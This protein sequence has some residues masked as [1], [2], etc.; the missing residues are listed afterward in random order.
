MKLLFHSQEVDGSK[1]WICGTLFLPDASESGIIRNESQKGQKC[2]LCYPV[3]I[4]LAKFFISHTH[5]V[6]KNTVVG[7]P[8]MNQCRLGWASRCRK[9]TDRSSD[10]EE[11][12]KTC[13]F[14]HLRCSY[15]LKQL[16]SVLGPFGFWVAIPASDVHGVLLLPLHYS[17]LQ[18]LWWPS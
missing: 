13:P 16:K 7:W 6:V 17:D 9:Q 15:H 2:S 4:Y 8:A 18:N 3:C 5:K 14:M 10:E 12:L 1:I 11:E